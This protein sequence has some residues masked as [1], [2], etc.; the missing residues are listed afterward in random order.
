VPHLD[1]AVGDGSTVS[2]SEAETDAEGNAKTILDEVAATRLGAAPIRPLEL[3]GPLPTHDCR[4]GE[5]I[6]EL[7]ADRFGRRHV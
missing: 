3:L 1:L 2:D 7:S 5:E 4:A 6:S